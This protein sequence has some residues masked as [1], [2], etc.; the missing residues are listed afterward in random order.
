MVLKVERILADTI[1]SPATEEVY[2]PCKNIDSNFLHRLMRDPEFRSRMTSSQIAM[3]SERL[4]SNSW[5][6][7]VKEVK[8]KVA[9]GDLTVDAIVSSTGFSEQDVVSALGALNKSG[10]VN[11]VATPVAEPIEEVI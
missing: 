2:N 3:A 4:E 9:E 5:P 11:L 7:V 8:R 6:S 1:A 10:K